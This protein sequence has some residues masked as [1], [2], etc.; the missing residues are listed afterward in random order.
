[1]AQARHKRDTDARRF[2]SKP[3]SRATL[4]A[5]PVAVVTTAAAVTVGLLSAGAGSDQVVAAADLSH[6]VERP[7]PVPS[8]AVRI[9]DRGTQ[10]SRSLTRRE[11]VAARTGTKMWTTADLDLWKRPGAAAAKDGEVKESTK[12]LVTGREL[13][14]R[15]EVVVDG[16]A[17]WVTKGHLAAEKPAPEPVEPPG[18]STEPCADSSVED[19]LKP[20]TVK[21][22][23]SVCHAFPEVT[24]YGG[25]AARTEHDTGNAIDVMVYGDKA[26]GDRIAAWAQAHAAELDLFD[27]LWWHRIWTPVRASEGWRTFSDRGS[28]TANHM[29]HVHLGTN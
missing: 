25:W 18:L 13:H 10:V 11:A 20:Q 5:A 14:G 21:V 3:F 29:D 24:E 16:A 26:L 4:V 12:V 23:R 17:R 7:A 6:A 19:G 1:V 22:Y 28:A 8:A 2:G 15:V 9:E 27:I